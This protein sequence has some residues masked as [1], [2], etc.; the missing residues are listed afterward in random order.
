MTNYHI[1]YSRVRGNKLVPLVSDI[2]VTELLL[3]ID[4]S[5]QCNIAVEYLDIG[6]KI[7]QIL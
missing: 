7:I 6:Q 4:I 5:E 3:E 2:T 1:S